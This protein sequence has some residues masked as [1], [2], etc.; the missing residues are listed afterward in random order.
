M[1]TDLQCLICP[2]CNVL[3]DLSDLSNFLI[4]RFVKSKSPRISEKVA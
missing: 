3:L 4:V 2:A 1:E